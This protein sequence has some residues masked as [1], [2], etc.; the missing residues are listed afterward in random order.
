MNRFNEKC[1][2][3]LNEFLSSMLGS[4]LKAGE[5]PSYFFSTLDKNKKNKEVQ[6]KKQI[7][8]DNPP[9]PNSLVVN[10]N[11]TEVTG[12]VASRMDKNGQFAV[13]LMNVNRKPSEFVFVKT[14]QKPYWRLEYKV[15]IDQNLQ[16]DPILIEKDPAGNDVSQI[17]PSTQIPYLKVGFNTRFPNWQD[18]EEFK[19]RK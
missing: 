15:T 17:S 8:T 3:I 18:L 6:Y 19:K 16:K 2:V 10:L 11:Q 13:Q 7:S 1:D 4:V 12:R 5:D 14:K 9:K